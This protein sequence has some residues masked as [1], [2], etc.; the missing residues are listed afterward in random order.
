LKDYDKPLWDGCINHSKLSVIAQVFTVKSNYGLSGI[1]YDRI[2]EW[3][4]NIL[5]ERNM[6]KE[7]FY[8]ANSMMKPL[9]LGYQKI[10][11]FP[12]FNMLYYLENIDLTECTICGYSRYQPRTGRRKI[13]VAYKKLH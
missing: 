6:M 8:S 4:R 3:A 9:G 10:D 2:V 7:N 11:M 1:G 13:L 12:N 5:P